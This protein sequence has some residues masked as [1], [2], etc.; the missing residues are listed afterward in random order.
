MEVFVRVTFRVYLG[1]SVY[2]ESFFLGNALDH[3]DTIRAM[4]GS[5]R[6]VR[7]ENGA[8]VPLG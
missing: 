3:A 4:G 1:D 5:P 6:I 2:A 7:V 8:E